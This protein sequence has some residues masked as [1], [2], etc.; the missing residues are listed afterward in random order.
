M[1]RIITRR[2]YL[3]AAGAASTP[4]IAG[5]AS[6]LPEATVNAPDT[7]RFDEPFTVTI[8]DLD[9]GDRV[10]VRV[11][12][13]HTEQNTWSAEATYE[14][15]DGHV[16]LDDD[17]DAIEG[18]E[19]DTMALIQSMSPESSYRED[20][21]TPT[22][23]SLTI[24]T[25]VR[26]ETV[27]SKTITRTRDDPEG[28]THDL[29]DGLAGIAYEPPGNDPAPGV[30]VLPWWGE[31]PSGLAA[32]FAGNGFFA[33]GL[34]YYSHKKEGERWLK[35]VP[36]ET[37]GRAAEWL[38]A[39]DRVSGSAVGAIG[40]SKGGE[41]ALLSGAMLSTVGAVVSVNG[42]GVVWDGAALD[43]EQVSPWS[44][45]DEPVAY[46][47][48]TAAPIGGNGTAPRDGFADAFE[49]A[50]EETVE[51]A[52]IPVEDVGGE[53][54]LV[55]GEDDLHWNSRAYSEIAADRLTD[56]EHTSEFDHLVF[57]GAG[58][59]I[60]YPY[61]PTGNR[62]LMMGY[63]YGGTPEGHA[64]AERTYWPAALETLESVAEE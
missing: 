52:T 63:E 43:D 1:E 3:V 30:V 47:P 55:S 51:E 12:T 57:E 36:V 27:G 24:E 10:T 20:Y 50:D 28:T 59:N 18:I 41:L 5:C 35:H 26:G 14:A 34:R 8:D 49:A 58:H 44:V 45:D 31:D 25:T 46:V 19:G 38:L 39:Q 42:S 16:D 32:A 61:L 21:R 6:D 13:T 53:V 40:L 7:V 9:A 22:E 62:N 60:R 48:T 2:S 29:P 11:S 15:T 64:E 4:W 23:E 37:V 33:V 54:L 56:H 17:D